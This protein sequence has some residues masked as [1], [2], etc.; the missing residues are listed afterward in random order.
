VL[1]GIPLWKDLAVETTSASRKLLPKVAAYF[2]AWTMLGL[3]F[4]SR[5]ATRRAYWDEP[6]VWGNLLTIWMVGEYIWG[7]LALAVF[8]FGSRWPLERGSLGR[9]VPLH[10]ALSVL[11]AA[12]QLALEAAAY[13]KLGTL[14]PALAGSFWT[15]WPALLVLGF[16]SN[17]IAYWVVLAVQTGYRYYTRFQEHAELALRLE[18]HASKLRAELSRA[19]LAALKMQLQPHFLFNTLNAITVLVRQK[20][21]DQAEEMLSRLSDLLRCVLDD[22]EAEEVP[23]YR[24]LEHVRLY[25]AIEQVRFQDRLTVTIDVAPAVLDAA[26]PHMALQPIVE[27]ALRHGVGRTSAAVAVHISAAA[28]AG[29]LEIRVKDD[30]PGFSAAELS[31]GWGIGLTNTRTRLQQLYG[32]GATLAFADGQPGAV[33]TIRL[34]YHPAEERATTEPMNVHA[35]YLP[36]R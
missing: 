20:S 22:V 26:V 16:H 34:P 30:G 36:D 3:F 9:R 6:V 2:L 19:Q 21:G 5:E 32:D 27:N 4:F 35:A 11:I 18:L 8:W 29:S 17:V 10:L 31:E 7:V 28:S 33:V 24:E 12:A 13:L 25:L 1:R 14:P 23:L 15:A